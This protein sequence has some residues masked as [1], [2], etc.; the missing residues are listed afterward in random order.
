MTGLGA[1]LLPLYVSILSLIFG[2]DEAEL[3]FVGDAMQHKAQLDAARASKTEYNYDNYFTE[4]PPC[5]AMADLAVVNLETPVGKPPYSGYPCFSAPAEFAKAL[6]HA[7]FDLF[8]TANNHTL[9]RGPDGLRATIATLDTLAL[10]HLGTYTDDSARVRALPLIRE[11][12][13][14]RIGFLNYTYGTNGITPSRGVVVDYIDRDRIKADVDAA[15][16]AGAEIIAVCMHWGDE[17]VLLPN[18]SQRNTADFLEA[19]GVDLIIGSHPHV[20]QPM[21]LRPNRYYPD[22]NVFLVYSLGNFV[23]NMK[24]PDTRGGALVRVRLR[25]GD[26]GKVNIDEASYKLLF[27]VPGVSPAD[28]FKVLEA[29]KVCDP[30]WRPKA[31]TFIERAKAV[32]DKHNIAVPESAE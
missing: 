17:Y 7:G 27:T 4:L 11:V 16:A 28:N 3:V 29:D 24:T 10:P 1:V 25:R 31:K 18:K 22:K 21:E 12:N 26:D 30:A 9:D 2:F 20:I 6:K 5:V 32:F 14:I 23:S 8:L 19:L 15:R 13:N